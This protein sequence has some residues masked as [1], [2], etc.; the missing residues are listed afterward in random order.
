MPG[1]TPFNKP[2]ICTIRCCNL[3]WHPRNS[4]SLLFSKLFGFPRY[5]TWGQKIHE[6]VEKLGFEMDIYVCTTLVDM[7][8]K[9]GDLFQV[10][11]LFICSHL[12]ALQHGACC[13]GYSFI[14]GFTSEF[15]I[16]SANIYMYSKSGNIHISR[17]VFYRMQKQ[18]VVSWNTMIIGY[19]FRLE[20]KLC[21]IVMPRHL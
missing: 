13:H 9:C 8:A 14:Q 16:C 21:D 1:K 7:Y 19:G 10:Q 2:Y 4:I 5:R 12:G 20:A 18:D 11:T 3:G 17:K 15:S 6:H